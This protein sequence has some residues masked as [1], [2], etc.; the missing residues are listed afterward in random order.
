[1][2]ATNLF[3][4]VDDTVSK[5]FVNILGIIAQAVMVNGSWNESIVGQTLPTSLIEMK[6]CTK[7]VA[8]NRYIV[9]GFLVVSQS[10]LV[11]IIWTVTSVNQ[12][13]DNSLLNAFW[14]G[15]DSE[16]PFSAALRI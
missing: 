12:L 15:G 16:E 7:G 10:H 8:E 14:L 6:E 4:E 2:M 11:T 3:N 1:M 5:L 9:T 13:L